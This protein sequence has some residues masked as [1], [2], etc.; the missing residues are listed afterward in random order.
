MGL[1]LNFGQQKMIFG[2]RYSKSPLHQKRIQTCSKLSAHF[3]T[4][5]GQWHPNI[6]CG[7]QSVYIFF[8]KIYL[9]LQDNLC[10]WSINFWKSC[11][12]GCSYERYILVCFR[13]VLRCY[14]NMCVLILLKMQG[15]RNSP[16]VTQNV[17]KNKMRMWTVK[18]TKLWILF[19]LYPE[20]FIILFQKNVFRVRGTNDLNI[21]LRC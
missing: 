19:H 11:Y 13:K 5:C 8:I 2:L 1:A 21:M 10:P 3:L 20:E 6:F 18:G 15:S 14:V 7:L 12:K 16:K 4:I 9:L 17:T